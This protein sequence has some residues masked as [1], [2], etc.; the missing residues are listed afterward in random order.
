VNLLREFDP[1]RGRVLYKPELPPREAAAARAARST[2]PFR[3][4]LEF[5][6]LPYWRVTP[7]DQPQDGLRVEASD[8]RFGAPPQSRFVAWAIVDAGGRVLEAHFRF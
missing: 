4:F 7:V 8:L 2:K 1:A 6:Q 5:S 3:S